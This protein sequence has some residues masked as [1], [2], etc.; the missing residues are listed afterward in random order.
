[1]NSF[2]K[3]LA[4]EGKIK[5]TEPSSEVAISYMS[6]AEKSLI[7]AKTL[8]R[9]ENYDDATALTYYSMYYS[10][11]AVLYNCGIKSENHTGTAILLKDIFGIENTNLKDAKKERVDKQYYVDC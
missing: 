9:I 10:A 6:K 4:A 11:L 3:K 2:I 1:M 7:S 8:S 5:L